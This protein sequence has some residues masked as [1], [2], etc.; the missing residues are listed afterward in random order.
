MFKKA[1]LA[2]VLLCSVITAANA[3][4]VIDRYRFGSSTFTPASVPDLALWLD[5]ADTATISQ[6]GGLVSQWDDKSGHGYHATQATSS[7]QFGTGSRTINGRNAVECDGSNDFMTL[8]SGL[9][10]MTTGATTTFIAFQT[11]TIAASN[12]LLMDGGATGF[13]YRPGW[14]VSSGI[15]TIHNAAS[16]SNEALINSVVNT[17]GPHIVTMKRDDVLQTIYFDGGS[18][19]TA[20]A[21]NGTMTALRICRSTGSTSP[22]DGLIGEILIYTRALN[23]TERGNVRSYL[24]TKWGT[25]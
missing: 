19:T 17:T 18:A 11:D 20:P 24:S 8:P 5:A 13:N 15:K 25:P 21:I 23:D 7:A 14:I 3:G 16:T 6:S 2:L 10:T 9:Y 12:Q 22:Y 4:I 1:I